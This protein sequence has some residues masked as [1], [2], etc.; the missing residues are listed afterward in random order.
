MRFEFSE[1]VFDDVEVVVHRLP[2]HILIEFSIQL[3]VLIGSQ[4][5]IVTL[6]VF[7]MTAMLY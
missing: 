1:V 6:T 3:V 5:R 7:V 4:L 2:S